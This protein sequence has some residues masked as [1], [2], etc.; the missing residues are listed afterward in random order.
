MTVE[1]AEREAEAQFGGYEAQASVVGDRCRIVL[2]PVSVER[3]P[4]VSAADFDGR[5]EAL[6]GEGDSFE[7]ALASLSL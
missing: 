1:Q 2:T 7:E 4:G 3:L 5:N 6:V